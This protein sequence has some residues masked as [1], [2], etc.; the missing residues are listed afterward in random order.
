MGPLLR[1]EAPEE[2]QGWA[3]IWKKEQI[4]VYLKHM[5]LSEGVA[6]GKGAAHTTILECTDLPKTAESETLLLRSI[7][8]YHG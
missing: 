7:T 2:P 1:P 4:W 5:G 3:Q 8:F 6:V